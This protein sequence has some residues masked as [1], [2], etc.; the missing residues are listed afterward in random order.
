MT[1]MKKIGLAIICFFCLYFPVKAQQDTIV[2]R[3]VLV[4]YGGELKNEMHPVAQAIRKTVPMDKRTTIL[5]LGDNLYRT[6]LPD[7]QNARYFKMKAVL[8][9]QVSIADN[10]PARIYM[11]PGNHDW[12][13]GAPGG[14]DAIIREQTYVDL[15]GKPNVEFYPKNG[16]PGPV[17]VSLDSTTTLILFDSQWWLH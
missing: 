7:D 16:C 3:I 6:G 17:E 1:V 8:D 9:S 5:F 11:I 10:T 15:L 2:R 12:E 13:N 4:G 14:Y